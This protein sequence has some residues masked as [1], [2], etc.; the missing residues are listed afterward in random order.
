MRKTLKDL[1]KLLRSFSASLISLPPIN[2]NKTIPNNG[3]IK[4]KTLFRDN[5]LLNYSYGKYCGVKGLTITGITKSLQ[6]MSVDELRQ[7][8]KTY[9]ATLNLGFPIE[10]ITDIKP[11]SLDSYLR[12][13][14][15][16]LDT[17]ELIVEN[18]PS[19]TSAKEKLRHLEKIKENVVQLGIPPFK[20]ITHILLRECSPSISDVINILNH[21]A[22]IIQQALTSTGLKTKELKA[23]DLLDLLS[24]YSGASPRKERKFF[25]SL[26]NAFTAS[27][28]ATPAMIVFFPA[29]MWK[30]GTWLSGISGILLGRNLFT[31]APVFWDLEETPS[32]HTIVVG[33]TGSG[34]TE[35]LVNL[36][37]KILHSYSSNTLI[38]DVKGEYKNRLMRRG[39]K[40]INNTLG[41]NMCLSFRNLGDL[42][43]ADL[44]SSIIT[45]EIATNLKIKDAE[46]IGIL[47]DL[48]NSA[49]NDRDS[50]FLKRIAEE[51]A[52]YEN[53][54]WTFQLKEIIKK[55][56]MIS[57]ECKNELVSTTINF[58]TN[59]QKNPTIID[60]SLA[61]SIDPPLVSLAVSV[62]FKA[63]LSVVRNASAALRAGWK[64][65]VLDEGWLFTK[66]LN[67]VVSALLRLGRS[68]KI[69]V[70]IATQDL[71]DLNTLGLSAISNTGL[72]V[73]MP[74]PE[75]KYW[76]ELGAYMRINEDEITFYTSLLG[77]GECVVRVLGDPRGIPIRY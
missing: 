74:T 68:Y 29:L 59:K 63:L 10:I 50:D 20:I 72:L 28:Y 8:I 19:L 3:E 44:R 61:Y 65:L 21:R 4:E 36:I 70:S 69:S 5:T 30:A 58:L 64:H 52:L 17:I 66:E 24:R 18:N 54:Y 45:E 41:K 46:L 47:Y 33:P 76:K 73:A 14:E 60:L 62:L 11:V 15:K 2:R 38:I 55:L 22:N 48:I 42:F 7:F 43:P 57:S 9:F 77:R 37:K 39:V 53:T 26:T 67:N 25:Q 31:N 49:L 23:K 27:V 71:D 1:P 16:E 56:R 51:I 35:F 32:P 12:E 13:V 6:E 75:R 34:K 40:S